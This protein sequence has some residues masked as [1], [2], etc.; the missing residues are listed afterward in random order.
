MMPAYGDTVG[1]QHVFVEWMQIKKNYYYNYSNLLT[2]KCAKYFD[3]LPT[4]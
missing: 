3:L 4:K 1:V 2:F